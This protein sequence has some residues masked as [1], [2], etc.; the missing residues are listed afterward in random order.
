MLGARTGH[1]CSRGNRSAEG[2]VS[3]VTKELKLENVTVL[4]AAYGELPTSP[5]VDPA[6]DVVFTWNGTTS[7]VAGAE[8]GLDRRRSGGVCPFAM[9]TFGL[10][11][12]GAR[13]AEA[14]R[15]HLLLAKKRWAARRRTAC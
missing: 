6:C 4:K 12:A 1:H 5:K 10:F 8:R 9:A 2:W 11:R 3:D 15:R 14:R 7:G 13:M